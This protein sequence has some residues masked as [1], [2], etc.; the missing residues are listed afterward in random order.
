ML[1]KDLKPEGTDG[2]RRAIPITMGTINSIS[3]TWIIAMAVGQRYTVDFSPESCGMDQVET[4]I[5]VGDPVT[6][7]CRK[8]NI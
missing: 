7:Y 3:G 2:P 4:M 5:M 6:Q 8:S 1:K